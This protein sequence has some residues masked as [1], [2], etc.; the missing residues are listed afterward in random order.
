MWSRSSKG[1]PSEKCLL[2][3][4]L[5]LIFKTWCDLS[6]KVSRSISKRVLSLQVSKGVAALQLGSAAL[7]EDEWLESTFSFLLI[8]LLYKILGLRFVVKT[9]VL[10]RIVLFHSIHRDLLVQ[11]ISS[12]KPQNCVCIPKRSLS[13]IL[14][15]VEAVSLDL[16]GPSHLECGHALL[17]LISDNKAEVV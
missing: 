10:P 9:L 3:I 17:L 2:P 4:W 13:T 16:L 8:T 14:G 12:K 7:L 6:R 15:N 11:A 1:E 5:L